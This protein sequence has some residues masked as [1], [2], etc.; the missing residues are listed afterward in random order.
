[1]KPVE[2]SLPDSGKTSRLSTTFLFFCLAPLLSAFSG[3]HTASFALAGWYTWPR[4]SRVI[5][6][7]IGVI[8]FSYEFV[9]KNAHRPT[10]SWSRSPM[11][12]VA[13]TCLVPYMLGGLTLGILVSLSE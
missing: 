3:F 6:L 2:A 11:E 5:V 8:I 1:M 13:L 9:F 4:T 12:S 7:T 10:Q